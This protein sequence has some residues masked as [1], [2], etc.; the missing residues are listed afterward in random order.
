MIVY[1]CNMK[2]YRYGRSWIYGRLYSGRRALKPHFIEGV[3][4]FITWAFA[5]ECCRSEGGVRFPCLKCERR[6]IIS[7]PEKVARH[8]H[9]RGFIENYWVWMYNGEELSSNVP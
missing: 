2:Y 5:Q 3:N 1:M 7:D 6:S 4:E 9:R 8:L